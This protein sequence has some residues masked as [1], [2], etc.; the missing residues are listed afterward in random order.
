MDGMWAKCTQAHWQQLASAESQQIPA[1]QG[2]GN[3]VVGA[4]DV[5]QIWTMFF[6]DELPL[7]DMLSVEG[8]MNQAHG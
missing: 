7:H 6:C 8:L 2:I 5:G 3:N 1:T 4:F